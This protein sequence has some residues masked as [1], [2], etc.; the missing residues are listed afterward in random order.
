MK[1]EKEI[2]QDETKRELKFF[3]NL[4]NKISWVQIIKYCQK[5]DRV[6]KCFKKLKFLLDKSY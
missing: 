4:Y 5:I 2:K 3:L 6:T 1:E